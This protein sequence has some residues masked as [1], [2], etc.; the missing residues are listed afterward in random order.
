MNNGNGTMEALYWGT[1]TSW[2]GKGD[3]NGPWI[4]ADLENGMF[5][6][7]AGCYNCNPGP[8]PSAK[9]L[10]YNYVSAFLKD[11]A[12]NWFALKGG[13]AQSG[14]LTTMWNDVRPTPNY[15]PKKLEGAIILGTG[16]DGSNGGTGTF[17]EGAMTIGTP[18]DSVDDAV[19]ANIVSAGYGR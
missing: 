2:G 17:F 6:G 8:W 5:K 18:P 11:P 12:A 19:Q 7:N 14:G 13:N 16:G 15:F 3:G 1:D 10:P 4:A 9:S